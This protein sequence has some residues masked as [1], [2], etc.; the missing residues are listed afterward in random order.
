[1]PDRKNTVCKACLSPR[2]YQTDICDY[3]ASII[4]SDPIAKITLIGVARMLNIQ[5]AKSAPRLPF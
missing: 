2:P 5:D 3:C 1:M 4:V